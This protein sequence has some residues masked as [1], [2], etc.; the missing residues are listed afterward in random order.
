MKGP[1][2]VKQLDRRVILKYTGL[3]LLGGVLSN[4]F[5]SHVAYAEPG[6]AHASWIHGH[7]M[8]IEYPDRLVS[9][10]R[11][12]FYIRV[13]GNS[14]SKNWFHFAIPTPVIVNGNRLKVGSVMLRFKTGSAD[15]SVKHVHVYDGEK[16]IAQHNNLNLHGEN[17][18]KRFD[19]PGHPPVKWGLGISI[20]VGFGVESMSHQMEF[21]SAGC[22][23]LS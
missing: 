6:L 20:G 16:K 11:A 2:S 5:A 8:H 3:G 10:W 9:E 22:D 15:A 13:E 18:F 23:F 19:V 21:T 4:K 17:M 7:S 12:G 1:T 14:G